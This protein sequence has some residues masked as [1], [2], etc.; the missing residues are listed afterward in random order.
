[1]N[2]NHLSS[3]LVGVLPQG[4]ISIDESNYQMLYNAFKAVEKYLLTIE[5]V[6]MGININKTKKT[7]FLRCVCLTFIGLAL[8]FTLSYFG[9]TLKIPEKGWDHVNM[10]VIDTH[11]HQIVFEY[12]YDGQDY[13]Y[14][15]K[16]LR[17]QEACH[18][19]HHQNFTWHCGGGGGGELCNQYHLN[20]SYY[21]Y[22]DFQNADISKYQPSSH[23]QNRYLAMI[24]IVIGGIGLLMVFFGIIY[25]M[26]YYQCVSSKVAPI[27]HTDITDARWLLRRLRKKMRK[28]EQ[29]VS[30]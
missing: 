7:N 5:H 3:K 24:G 6:N 9:Y 19:L 27:L 18:W 25:H 23:I 26:V 28:I 14:C 21:L 16:T 17:D 30:V 11:Q 2:T 20:Q 15:L 12:L 13:S 29:A 4:F 8:L 10:T 1:M 22:V